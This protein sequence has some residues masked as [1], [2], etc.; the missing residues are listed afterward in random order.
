M[1][2]KNPFGYDELLALEPEF[3]KLAGIDFK[4]DRITVSENVDEN[5]LARFCSEN[6]LYLH[7]TIYKRTFPQQSLY[8]VPPGEEAENLKNALLTL[9]KSLRIFSEKELHDLKK[10]ADTVMDQVQAQLYEGPGLPRI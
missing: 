9:E 3:K 2:Y 1:T 4:L 10:R 8:A 6:D 7:S 5:A